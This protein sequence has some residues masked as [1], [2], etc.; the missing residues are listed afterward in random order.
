M[1]TFVSFSV[2]YHFIDG[3]AMVDDRSPMMQ[4][5]LDTLDLLCALDKLKAIDLIN[6][7]VRFLC[8]FIFDYRRQLDFFQVEKKKLRI[9]AYLALRYL[10]P[11]SVVPLISGALATADDQHRT[12]LVTFVQAAQKVIFLA[13]ALYK[14]L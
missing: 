9:A 2:C 10:P 13:R 11:E 4:K 12:A 8:G 6:Y 14:S 3:A 5:R 1:L 7:C